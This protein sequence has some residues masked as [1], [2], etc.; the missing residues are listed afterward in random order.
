MRVLQITNHGLHEWDVTPGLPDTGGQN[1]YVNQMSAAL[2]R[3][4]HAVTI[5]NRGGYPHPLTGELRTGRVG[6]LEGNGE[7]I[8][9]TD[10]VEA[11]VRKEDMADRI[12]GLVDE[13]VPL[14]EAERFDLIVS[15]YWDGGLIGVQANERL[16]ESLPHVWIP[17]SLGAL[18]KHNVDP[19]VWPDLRI[20]ERI[21]HERHLVR[22]VDGIAATSVAIRNTLRSD[23][24]HE[25]SHFL[26]PGVDEARYHPR[27]EAECEAT[28]DLLAAT[29]VQSPVELIGRPL[30]TEVS[31]TD[32]TK[33]KDILIRAFARAREAVPDALLA[34]TIDR[35]NQELH[36]SLRT[37]I[38]EL[39]LSGHVAVL[40]SVWEHLPCLYA[41]TDVYCTPSVMEGFGMSAQEAAASGVPVVAS[42]LVPFATEFL[43]GDAPESVTV[44]GADPVLVGDGAVVVPAD[45]VA[46]FAH[47][48]VE[49]LMDQ[50]LRKQLGDAALGITVPAFGWDRLVAGFLETVTAATESSDG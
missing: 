49:L 37:L 38:E 25:P 34:V 2:V 4:G 31:R 1:V 16:Q 28:W 43:L 8:Y 14:I 17:H 15:H 41:S 48:L 12:P 7:I 13:L 36:D 33:R 32:T 6:G 20:D 50:G 9:L 29:M 42:D 40:G 39:G 47:A 3:L 30:V 45:S 44:P 35:A 46:G 24:G 5:V 27:E 19:S 23:Y 10:D 18:K 21:E 22:N 11:F 26:P